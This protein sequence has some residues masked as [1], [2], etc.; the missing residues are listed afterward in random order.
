MPNLVALLMHKKN[1]VPSTGGIKVVVARV[2]FEFANGSFTSVREILGWTLHACMAAVSIYC[3]I[4]YQHRCI[5]ILWVYKKRQSKDNNVETPM[6]EMEGNPC[7]ET[8]KRKQ[9]PDTAGLQELPL[10]RTCQKVV[11]CYTNHLQYICTDLPDSQAV[12]HRLI[13]IIVFIWHIM[14]TMHC[15]IYIIQNL[16]WL[17]VWPVPMLLLQVTGNSS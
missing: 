9:I 6:Y 11:Q 17:A 7:Y 5:I 13:I 15:C 12:C 4:H 16:V 2:Y 10:Q 3:V 14:S 8:S 1:Q